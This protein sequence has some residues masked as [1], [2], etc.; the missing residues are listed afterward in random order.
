LAWS[1]IFDE[2]IPL[3]RGR[4]LATLEDAGSYITRLPTVEHATAEWQAA[5]EAL[6]LIATLGRPTMF[7][8]IGVMRLRCLAGSRLAAEASA[9]MSK[10]WPE[11]NASSL[12]PEKETPRQ[13]PRMVLMEVSSGASV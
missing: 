6:I 8:R 13:C 3:L 2:P 5:M 1:R 7:A 10:A 12:L 9:P 11:G 4:A